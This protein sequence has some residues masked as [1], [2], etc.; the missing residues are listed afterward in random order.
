MSL[1]KVICENPA[2][3]QL[4]LEEGAAP[5]YLDEIVGVREIK[6][7]IV[8][9]SAAGASGKKVTGSKAQPRTITITLQI[10]ENYQRVSDRL[11]SFFQ[12]DEDCTLYY[13]EDDLARKIGYRVE[14]INIPE[15]GQKRVV[16]VVLYCGDPLFYDLAET[17]VT[18]STWLGL[19]EFPLEIINPFEVAERLND[20]MVEIYNAS[21]SRLGLRVRFK[22]SG[23][24]RSPMIVDAN[25]NEILRLGTDA[26]P[27]VMHAGDEIEITTGRGNK[28]ATLIS[29]G[30]RTNII[31]GVAYP[32]H[33]IQLEKGQ[34][35]LRYDAEE[36][37]DA[38]SVDIFYSNVY[39]GV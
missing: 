6:H 11:Y 26:V 30:T 13:Y 28:S 34:N 9:T 12:P 7:D 4:V 20:L 16:T 2:G 38:L 33:W 32:P 21:N 36:G 5:Y 1:C 35:L 23:E 18:L 22:A 3:E 17:K 29:G 39:W 8:T 10:L 14:S 24:V 15:H 27:I 31:N 37:I 25:R 19:I